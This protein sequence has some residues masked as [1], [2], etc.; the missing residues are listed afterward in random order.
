MVTYASALVA[1]VERYGEPTDV[2]AVGACARAWW[3]AAWD[4]ESAVEEGV[5]LA[6]THLGA[7]EL[8]ALR[9]LSS[10]RRWLL[11]GPDATPLPDALDAAARW[12]RSSG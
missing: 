2:Y 4:G 6:E 8:H 11:T 1:C 10:D 12:L 3:A 9:G 7:V 5:M